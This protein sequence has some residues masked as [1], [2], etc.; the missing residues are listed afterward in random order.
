M[1]LPVSGEQ[2][3][4]SLSGEW[5]NLLA[6]KQ[7]FAIRRGVLKFRGFSPKNIPIATHNLTDDDF[8]E[9]FE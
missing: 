8:V 7:Q 9:T 3:H 2:K 4:L 1:P 6:A 5:L